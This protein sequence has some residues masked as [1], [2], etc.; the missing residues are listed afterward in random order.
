MAKDCTTEK[1]A[2]RQEW[3]ENALLELMLETTF[4]QITVTHLCR[5]L[6]LGRRS[7]YRYFSDL[8]DVLDSAMNRLFQQM[9]ITNRM[10]ELE[11]IR[12]NYRFWLERR[13]V[14]DALNRSGMLDR[15]F[16]YLLRYSDPDIIRNY[17]N[18]QAQNTGLI[19]EAGMFAI[20]GSMALII[21]WY[22]GGFVKSP[23][24]MANIVYQMLYQ[25]ILTR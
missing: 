22:E 9:A 17:L 10:P 8:E 25:P 7:F 15:L 3:I 14:L 2:Q 18:P 20:G 24:E 21:S 1:T 16:V 11:E 6:G 5:R 13:N 12:D 4:D 23:E 19:R